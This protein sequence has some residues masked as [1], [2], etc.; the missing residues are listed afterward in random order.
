MLEI[1]ICNMRFV[2]PKFEWEFRVDRM[3]PVGNPFYMNDESQ[4]D[5]VCDKYESYFQTQLENNT[6]FKKYLQAMLNALKQY[7][8]LYLYCWCAPKRCHA[9]TIKRW[10]E[11]QIE[12]VA[13]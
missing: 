3:S 12:G 10:L 8:K 13:E 1:K 9:E 2:K 6:H 4:R 7:G 11:N 5:I